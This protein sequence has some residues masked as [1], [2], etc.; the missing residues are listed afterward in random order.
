MFYEL[1]EKRKK[2]L[3]FSCFMLKLLVVHNVW[4]VYINSICAFVKK[5]RFFWM[6]NEMWFLNFMPTQRELNESITSGQLVWCLGL[7]YG[8][9]GSVK[10]HI[11]R[12]VWYGKIESVGIRSIIRHHQFGIGWLNI[13]FHL[14]QQYVY[15]ILELGTMV[16]NG[17]TKHIYF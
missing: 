8:K 13:H 15:D 7:I 9:N 4:N 1:K 3:R 2:L 6:A 5:S 14:K 10:K 12:M 16:Q 11:H 17:Y